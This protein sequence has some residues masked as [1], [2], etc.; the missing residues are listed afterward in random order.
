MNCHPVSGVAVAR[1]L[2]E[3]FSRI[4]R[5]EVLRLRR[6]LAPLDAQPRAIAETIVGRVVGPSWPTPYA[7]SPKT[8]LKKVLS[9]LMPIPRRPL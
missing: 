9:G 6:K 3:D 5:A 7:C 2:Q 4:G 8:G 1:M